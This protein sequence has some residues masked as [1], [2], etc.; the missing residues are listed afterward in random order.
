MIRNIYA[1]DRA[2]LPQ[3]TVPLEMLRQLEGCHQTF[4]EHGDNQI[5]I[6]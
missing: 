1:H 4:G 3:T 5:A 6:N 2:K